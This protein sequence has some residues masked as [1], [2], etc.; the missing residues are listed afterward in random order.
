M[1]NVYHVQI[2]LTT[3]AYLIT[4]VFISR[5]DIGGILISSVKYL[6]VRSLFISVVSQLRFHLRLRVNEIS[7]VSC[8]EPLCSLRALRRGKNFYSETRNIV[9]TMFPRK[10]LNYIYTYIFNSVNYA[11]TFLC[12]LIS[13]DINLVD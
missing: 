3:N 2:F 5:L 6:F 13:P 10:Y 7:F 9:R 12:I 11:F 8:L 1:D 4:R